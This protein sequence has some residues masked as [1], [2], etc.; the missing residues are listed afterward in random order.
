MLSRTTINNIT[1]HSRTAGMGAGSVARTFSEAVSH[2]SSWHNRYCT[3][4]APAAGTVKV[5]IPPAVTAAASQV[6]L[7]KV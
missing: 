1:P 7:T 6:L 4:Q 2:L 5:T 3:V